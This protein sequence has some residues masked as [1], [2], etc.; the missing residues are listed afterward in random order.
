MDTGPVDPVAL[1][2]DLDFVLLMG[3]YFG[4]RVMGPDDGL[5]IFSHSHPSDPRGHHGLCFSTE[6]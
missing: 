6:Y 1:Q 5:K 3:T 4:G 2:K